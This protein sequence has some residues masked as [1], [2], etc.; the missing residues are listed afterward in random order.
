MIVYSFSLIPRQK[1]VQ[2][3]QDQKNVCFLMIWILNCFVIII[4]SFQN[5]ASF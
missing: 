3:E 4:I 1:R 2:G 5:R